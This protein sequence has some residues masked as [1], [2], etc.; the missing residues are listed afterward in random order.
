MRPDILFPL[1]APV[2]SL[3]GIGPRM[4]KLVANVAGANVVDLLWHLPRDVID[5]SFAPS[6]S[7]A[8]E[9]GIASLRVTVERHMPGQGRRPYRVRC[10]DETGFLTLIFFHPR[11]DYLERA[12]PPGQ[13]RV[14]SG[15][16]ESYQ[17]ERQMTH[18]DY[19]LTE[20]EA[21][22]MPRIEPVYGLTA[23]LTLR[24]LG[25][26]VREALDRA[27]DLAEWQDPA[28]HKKRGWLSWREALLTVHRPVS[29]KDLE[30]TQ[31]HRARLAYDE[32][33][34][35]QLALALVRAAAEK[36][37]GAA[38]RRATG[39]CSRRRAAALPFA[40][41]AVAA[42]GAGR[43]RRRHGGSRPHA[44]AAAGRCRQRQDGGRAARHAD[45]G[46]GRRA[47][48]R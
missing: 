22:T 18:P 31:P 3:P 28:F 9:G 43:D 26:A 33:L 4:A 48:R 37:A 16:I 32:L 5:R 21:E 7:A 17:G 2:T 40:L 19:I 27:P 38:A 45:R 12:L 1:F 8:P 20:A 47:R 23:G 15:T 41:T 24:T 46:R 29:R 34:A 6:I 44:A 13:I 11:A 14:V 35:N 39:G 30:P 36:A 25:K 42:P 10:A